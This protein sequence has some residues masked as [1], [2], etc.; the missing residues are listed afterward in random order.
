MPVI[1]LLLLLS[2][3][4]PQDPDAVVVRPR[5]DRVTVY[6]GEALLERTVAVRADAPGPRLFGPDR[7]I[8]TD[9]GKGHTGHNTPPRSSFKTY[10]AISF[11][12][13]ERP[14]QIGLGAAGLFRQFSDGI[15]PILGNQTEKFTVPL[16]EHLGKTFH[17]GEPDRR[18]ILSGFRL[19]LGNRQSPRLH[20]LV[21]CDTN[22]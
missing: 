19:A 13:L 20:I 4:A 12:G 21:T 10:K 5:L 17:R 7:Q 14:R 16:G 9:T 6:P 3:C 22:Y 11:H 8:Q 15:W 2:L 1:S 18:I